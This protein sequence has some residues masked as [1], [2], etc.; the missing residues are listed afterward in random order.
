VIVLGAGL[1]GLAAAY[2]LVH[3][4][5]G[6]TV[7]EARMRPGGRVCT[8]REPFSDGLYAEAGA[9]VF[10]DACRHL[11]RYA[12]LFDLPTAASRP[13]DLA[14]LFHLR[15]K[16]IVVKPGQA[17][18]WPFELRADEHELGLAGLFDRHVLSALHDIPDP[19][20]AAWWLKSAGDYD[21]SSF[22]EL[23]AARG[24]S[25]EAVELLSRTLWFGVGWDTKSALETL[26]ADV[27]LFYRGG[28]IY[29]IPGGNDRLPRA[30]ASRLRERV[31]YGSAV[32]NIEEGS[33]PV[34]VVF[35]QGG[36]RHSM[37]A[38]FLI[39]TIP[40]SVLRGID[41][42][43]PLS[44]EKR[45]ALEQLRYESVTRVFLQVS[46]R[47][48][49]SGGIAGDAFTDLPIMQVQEH[50]VLRQDVRSERSILEAHMRGPMAARMA[51]MNEAD[52]INLVRE[53]MEKVHPGLS[54]FL[55][56]AA[57]KSWDEDEWAR[58]A[59]SR[60]TPGQMTVWLPA[61]ARPEGRI[62]FGGEHTSVWNR[63][64]EGA[65][66]SGHRAAREVNEAP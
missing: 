47:F 59:Y 2:E 62:H 10:S 28:S 66:E 30:F 9:L 54:A 1:A 40:F 35:L 60:F 64:M 27:A 16:R 42:R 29:T 20:D 37:E 57:S 56:R 46:E 51:H 55:E 4:G 38:D 12:R 45:Q 18:P 31:R 39:C 58:G 25:S 50:P 8:L 48:W 17:P 26:L 14:R 32:V 15:G 41:I 61:I 21:R 24:A 33:G 53:Q 11:L 63:T 49:T 19:I 6:V 5:H 52:R 65:L 36:V 22:A 3:A 43:A 44:K 34:R 23:L 7:L 13:G